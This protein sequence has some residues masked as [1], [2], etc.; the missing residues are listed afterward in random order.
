MTRTWSWE[1]MDYIG[2]EEPRLL[3]D[4]WIEPDE[5]CAFCGLTEQAS[6]TRL[7]VECGVCGGVAHFLCAVDCTPDPF[8]HDEEYNDFV[9]GTCME[10]TPEDAA[11]HAASLTKPERASVAVP[12]RSV[13][14]DDFDPFF[15]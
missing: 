8:E 15:D 4:L 12:T 11:Q 14:D 3:P 5:T 13:P 7:V 1:E 6:G 9:C 2:E 10:W